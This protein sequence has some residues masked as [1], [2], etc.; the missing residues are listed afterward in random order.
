MNQLD[1]RDAFRTGGS[2]GAIQPQESDI[3]R[4]PVF[5]EIDDLAGHGFIPILI[6]SHSMS[7]GIGAR[8]KLFI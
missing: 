4:R 6:H 5:F 8:C 2:D 3:Y 7:Y 1:D